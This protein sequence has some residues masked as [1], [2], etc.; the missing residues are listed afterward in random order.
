[1]CLERIEQG[2]NFSDAP[3]A[4]NAGDRPPADYR[5]MA[6]DLETLQVWR[7]PA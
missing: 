1:M 4:A 2:V 5:Q 3:A 7:V 6:M